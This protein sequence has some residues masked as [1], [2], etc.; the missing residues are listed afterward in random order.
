M[1]KTRVS[2]H[3]QWETPSNWSLCPLLPLNWWSAEEKLSYSSLDPPSAAPVLVTVIQL[4]KFLS[5][6]YCHLL[7]SNVLHTWN[8]TKLLYCTPDSMLDYPLPTPPKKKPL[9]LRIIY[10]CLMIIYK[11]IRYYQLNIFSQGMFESLS[12]SYLVFPVVLS[13]IS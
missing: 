10:C 5:D 2:S 9:I 12:C 1:C 3:F 11:L 13:S 8:I 6:S 4:L 7:G